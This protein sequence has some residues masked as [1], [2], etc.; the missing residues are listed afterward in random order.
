MPMTILI[1]RDVP[2]RVRGFVG[3]VMLELGPGFY[4]APVLS[5]AVRNRIWQVL[6]DWQ[7]ELAQG[8]V[9]LAWQDARATGGIGLSFLGTP[10]RE[11]VE[12]DGLYLSR[13][14]DAPALPPR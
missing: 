8:S 11:I 4:V 5:A 10:A 6:T 13:L 12:H 9:V 2:D 7:G 1:T 3:S 14:R